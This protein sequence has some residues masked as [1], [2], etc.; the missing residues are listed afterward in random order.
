[1]TEEEDNK[2]PILKSQV[3]RFQISLWRRRIIIAARND[4]EAEREIE[5]VRMCVQYSRYNHDTNAW[6]NQSIWCNPEELRDLANVMDKLNEDTMAKS[7]PHG[8]VKA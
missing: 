8:G 7:V 3:G 2:G 4:F 6:D 5:R 1:M